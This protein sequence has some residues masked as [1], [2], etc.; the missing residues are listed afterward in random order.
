MTRQE[1]AQA[2]WATI[3]ERRRAAGDHAGADRALRSVAILAP[4]GRPVEPVAPRR[5]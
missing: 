3:A 2:L 4:W 1:D 5:W